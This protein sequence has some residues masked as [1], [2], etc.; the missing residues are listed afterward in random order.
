[1]NAYEWGLA[2]GSCPEALKWRK[3]LAPGATQADAWRLCPRGD[4]M[5]WQ[6]R[7]GLSKAELRAVMPALLRAANKIV[8]RAG[9][10]AMESL[11]G[12]DAPWAAAWRA[13]AERWLSGADRSAAAASTAAAEAETAE[14]W[15]AAAA[16]WAAATWAEAWAAAETAEAWA[17]AA[18]WAEAVAP[19]AEAAWAEAVALEEEQVRQAEDLRSEI[20]EWPGEVT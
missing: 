20:P 19:W 8:A 2:R 17:A 9:W 5:G 4:W 14:A 16:A 13:W 12:S 10:R 3:S 6:L 7:Y 11:V 18:A 15:A 1:M